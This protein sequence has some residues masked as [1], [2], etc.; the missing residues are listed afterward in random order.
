MFSSFLTIINK[1]ESLIKWI[2]V[3]L[4]TKHLFF[5]FC[6]RFFILLKIK[7]LLVFFSYAIGNSISAQD[8]LG[9][10]LC[11]EHATK[12][13]NYFFI[14]MLAD[15]SESSFTQKYMKL[16]FF[17]VLQNCKP[18]HGVFSCS[19]CT[20]TYVRISIYFVPILKS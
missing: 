19:C 17:S 9:I 14:C 12:C 16:N 6:P 13:S 15:P 4:C 7:V 8:F 18:Y 10:F 2:Q 5:L 20:R 11:V 3:Q 1:F